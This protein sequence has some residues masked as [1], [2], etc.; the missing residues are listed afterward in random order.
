MVDFAE[1]AEV[2]RIKSH[3]EAKVTGEFDRMIEQAVAG[4]VLFESR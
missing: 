4:D 1:L 2:Y 3:F